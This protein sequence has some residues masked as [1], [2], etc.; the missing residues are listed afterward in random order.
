MKQALVVFCCTFLGVAHGSGINSQRALFNYQM[1]CQGCHT[2]DGSGTRGVPPMKGQVGYFTQTK[3]G[4]EYL[5]QVPGSAISMLNSADLAEVLNWVV[6]EF[7]GASLNSAFEPY[8][9]SEVAR[10][11][12]QPLNEIIQRRG[13]ILADIAHK[14][15]RGKH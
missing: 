5:V 7:S 4:R 9:P 11:R 6:R 10:L 13:E 2:P 15:Q 1:F 12:Q 8:T 3:S 14:M